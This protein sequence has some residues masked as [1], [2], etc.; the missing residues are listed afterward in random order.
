MIIL[1]YKCHC[2]GLF[3]DWLNTGLKDDIQP[4]L[5]RLCELRR[6]MIDEMLS[7]AMSTAG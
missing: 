7:R 5:S 3:I 2:F 4:V 6:G 1:S